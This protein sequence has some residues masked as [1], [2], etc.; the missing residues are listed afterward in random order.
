MLHDPADFTQW[1]NSAMAM[2]RLALVAVVLVVTA[3]LVGCCGGKK[4][5][6]CLVYHPAETPQGR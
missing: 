4:A 3:V 1:E 5:A 6:E 2:R